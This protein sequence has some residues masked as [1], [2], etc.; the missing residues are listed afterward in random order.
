M[1]SY[2]HAYHAGNLADVHKHA[3]LAQALDYLTQKNKPL[4]Y[5][6]THA[7]RGLYDLTSAEAQKTGEAAQGISF[8]SQW[9]GKDHPYTRALHAIREKRGP[10]AYPG[11]PLIAQTLLRESDRLHLAELHPQE[12]AALEF[13]MS[14]AG[15]A[16]VYQQDGFALAQSLCPPD[17]RRGLIL[18]DPS[19]ELKE[20]YAR[21]P[22]FVDTL[23]KKWNVGI[24]MIWYPI[25]TEPQHKPMIAAIRQSQS[26]AL[27]HEVTFPPARKGHRMVGSGMVVLNPPWGLADHAQALTKRFKS[28]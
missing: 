28:L 17:P 15:N 21:M 13:T 22:R 25:L 24:V 9:F 18:I 8:V 12:H 23:A 1:L 7:G 2:Q 11:S 26:E 27:I 20:D 5:L 14:A 16:K 6:E 3:L 4:T 10:N 19:W